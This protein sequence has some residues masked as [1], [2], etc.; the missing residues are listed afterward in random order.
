MKTVSVEPIIGERVLFPPGRV[1]VTLDAGHRRA[2]LLLYGQ[3][4]P[5][6]DVPPLKDHDFDGRPITMRTGELA[7]LNRRFRALALDGDPGPPG[8]FRD[9]EQS[10]TETSGQM[11]FLS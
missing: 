4:F 5:L 11:Q 7:A 1:R 6:S 2:Y 3:T 8:T 9:Q 10:L